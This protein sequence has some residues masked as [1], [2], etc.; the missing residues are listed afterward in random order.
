MPFSRCRC[1]GLRDR[2]LRIASHPSNLDLE[3]LHRETLHNEMVLRGEGDAEEHMLPER[4]PAELLQAHHCDAVRRLAAGESPAEGCDWF[5][6]SIC[7]NL[8]GPDAV[9]APCSHIFCYGCIFG[10]MSRFCGA[11]GAGDA[12]RRGNLHVP[13]PQC[14]RFVLHNHLVTVKQVNSH[15][16]ASNVEKELALRLRKIKEPR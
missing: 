9:I 3:S 4:T 13:C 6:C 5:T 8:M 15:H 1:I 10:T 14:R 7:L 12:A 16:K 2:L 11:K